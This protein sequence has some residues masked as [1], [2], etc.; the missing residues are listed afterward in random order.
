MRT[1]TITTIALL[2]V[3]ILAGFNLTQWWSWLALLLVAVLGIGV[4]LAGLF[5]SRK[6]EGRL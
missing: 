6:W 1:L 3:A 5:L 2:A 4:A